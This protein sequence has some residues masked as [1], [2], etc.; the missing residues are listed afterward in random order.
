[1]IT[2][3][4]S[5]L[6]YMR[7][8]IILLLVLIVELSGP[9]PALALQAHGYKGLYVHQG[10]HIFFLLALLSFSFRIHRSGLISSREWRWI[11]HGAWLLALWNI[12]AFSGHFI[13]LAIPPEHVTEVAG[14]HVPALVIASWKEITF[15]ILKMDH[16]LS[17]PAIFCFYT[18]LRI[19]LKNSGPRTI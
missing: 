6:P 15:F 7:C 11:S 10:A 5:M 9:S 1:M 12:W 13:E 4:L 3:R 16:L 2:S 18:G 14:N 8:S 17:V 19:M